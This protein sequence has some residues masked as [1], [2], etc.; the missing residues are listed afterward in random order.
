M[1]YL[2]GTCFFAGASIAWWMA[3]SLGEREG[4]VNAKGDHARRMTQTLDLLETRDSN[5]F[6]RA[7][8]LVVRKEMEDA[9]ADADTVTR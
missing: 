8:D 7:Y 1:I 3:W 6:L 9:N 5:R 2:M 4:Y